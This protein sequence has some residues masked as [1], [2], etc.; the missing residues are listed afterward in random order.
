MAFFSF[1]ISLL[2]SGLGPLVVGALSD[3]LTPQFGVDGLRYAI[4]IVSCAMPLCG[5]TMW[6]AGLRMPT[7]VEA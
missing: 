4:L 7:D 6:R 3:A 5:L 1:T 2:G